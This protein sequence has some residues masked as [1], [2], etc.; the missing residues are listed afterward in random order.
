VLEEWRLLVEHKSEGNGVAASGNPENGVEEGDAEVN[1]AGNEM[2]EVIQTGNSACS[3]EDHFAADAADMVRLGA[4]Q[5]P[6]PLPLGRFYTRASR[7]ART[8]EINLLS[9]SRPTTFSSPPKEW[10][11][12]LQLLVST[13]CSLPTCQ[14]I[15][16][17]AIP[18][19]WH[20]SDALDQEG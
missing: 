9:S 19:V 10:L 2:D 18:R 13:F 14:S 5:R 4:P 20:R 17:P 11:S 7:R 8:S 3:D 15:G 16:D 1:H 12:L 6:D